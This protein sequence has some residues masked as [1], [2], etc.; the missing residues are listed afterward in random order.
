MVLI[1]RFL[2]SLSALVCILPLNVQMVLAGNDAADSKSKA[3]YVYSN[4]NQQCI[5]ASLMGDVLTLKKKNGKTE[6][7]SMNAVNRLKEQDFRTMWNLFC[8]YVV[9]DVWQSL[10]R[11]SKLIGQANFTLEMRADGTYAVKRHALYVPGCAPC[12]ENAPVPLKAREFWEQ[13][14]K[15]IANIERKEMKIPGDDVESVGLELVV[16]R[17]LQVFPR[18]PFGT[19]KKLLVRKKDGSITH[20][21]PSD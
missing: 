3:I 4:T 9:K 15:S 16:G 11:Q 12:L 14:K 5:E 1:K 19:Y 7:M 8:F 13:I 2:F 18:Y 10:K 17:D 6:T 20:A 21:L